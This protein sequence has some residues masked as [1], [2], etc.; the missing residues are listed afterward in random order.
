MTIRIPGAIVT[1]SL[2]LLCF[3]GAAHAGGLMPR[4]PDDDDLPRIDRKKP[5]R[6]LVDGA[7]QLWRVQCDDQNTPDKK[8]ILAPDAQLDEDNKFAGELER[9]VPC[10]NDG[11]LDLGAL[12]QDGYKIVHGIAGAPAGWARDARGRV[13]QV[14]FDLHDRLW[15]GTSWQPGRRSGQDADPGGMGIDFGVLQLEI[16]NED[17]KDATRHR[18]SV[19]SGEVQIAPF[20]ADVTAL[21]YD[22]SRRRG[23]PLLRLSTFIGKPRRFDIDAHLG[24]WFEVGRLTL[25]ERDDGVREGLVR[26][27]TAN[28]T[29]DIVRSADMYSYLRVRGGAG[30]E[31]VFIDDTW[32]PD[33]TAL[34]PGATLEGNW[35]LDRAGLN[36]LTLAG[37]WERPIGRQKEAWVGLGQRAHLGLGYERIVIAFN[38]QPVTLRV[39]AEADYRS[40][41][42][43]QAAGWDF[44]GLIGLRFNFWAPAR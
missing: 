19:L 18:L 20:G 44:K 27:A 42:P 34:T 16:F 41:I 17:G 9:A 8:C 28:L 37:T 23:N 13:F 35:T 24:G 10:G 11:S 25:S 43:A 7:G 12:E 33:R 39:A 6:C 21:R 30:L 36:H 31:R 26:L 4:P 2:L 15:V 32:D 40:D 22:F 5:F 38:D 3:V 14:E 29:W 1:L